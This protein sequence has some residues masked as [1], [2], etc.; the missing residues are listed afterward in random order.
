MPSKEELWPNSTEKGGVAC[1]LSTKPEAYFLPR[2]LVDTKL[3][4]IE[5]C[6]VGTQMLKYKETIPIKN[7]N[8]AFIAEN[9]RKSGPYHLDNIQ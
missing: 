3:E 9:L 2:H 8:A 1:F 5:W 6:F 4:K 7:T